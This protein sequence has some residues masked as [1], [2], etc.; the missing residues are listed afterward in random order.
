[1]VLAGSYVIN[2]DGSVCL[3]SL[4]RKQKAAVWGDRLQEQQLAPESKKG[5]GESGL[6]EWL[7]EGTQVQPKFQKIGNYALFCMLF[8]IFDLPQDPGLVSHLDFR[9]K[10][11]FKHSFLIPD[12]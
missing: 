11:L 8:I 10:I 5:R 3:R 7:S 9:R 12:I 1:M 4:E 2:L 6:S